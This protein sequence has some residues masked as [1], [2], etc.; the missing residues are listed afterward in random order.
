MAV[1]AV[2]RMFLDRHPRALHCIELAHEMPRK[3]Q[4]E[5]LDL[6][7]A[8]AREREHGVLLR[9]GGEDLAVVAGQVRRGEIARQGDADG[10]VLDVVL[11]A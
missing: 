2:P 5:V 7:D 10:Q 3:A 6:T 11:G 1:D 8:V 4:P 9:V